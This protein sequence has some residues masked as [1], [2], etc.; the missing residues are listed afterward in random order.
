[1]HQ[2]IN[3]RASLRIAALILLITAPMLIGEILA[4]KL[5]VVYWTGG[6]L[7]SLIYQPIRS[8]GIDAH[9]CINGWPD[10]G[11]LCDTFNYAFSPLL[12][13]KE[14]W[15]WTRR[16]FIRFNTIVTTYDSIHTC[17]LWLY[18]TGTATHSNWVQAYLVTSPWEETTVTWATAPSVNLTVASDR[19]TPPFPNWEGWLSLNIAP[20]Y[21]NWVAGPNYGLQLRQQDLDSDDGQKFFSSDYLFCSLSIDS[22]WVSEETDCD[23]QNLVEICYEATDYIID[24]IFASLKIFHDGALVGAHTISETVPGFPPPNLGWVSSG[25]KC[26]YW[27]MSADYPGNEGCDFEIA[28]DVMNETTEILT[29]TDS[30]AIPDAE[31]VAWDGE[32]LWVTRSWYNSPL[33]TQR[34]FRVDP[35]THEVFDDSCITDH[36][37][38]GYTADCVWHDGY[39]WILGGGLSGQRAKLFKFDV[40]TCTVVDSSAALW[41]GARWGQGICYHDGWFYAC[42]SNGK[43]YRVETTPP[44]TSTLWLDLETIHP[45]LMSGAI[46]ADALVF[47]LGFIWIL[48]NPGPAGHVL[49]QFD[50]TGN[51]IDSFALASLTGFGPEGITFDGECF[52]YTDHAKDFVY[53]VC[54]WGCEDS[55]VVAVCLDSKAPEVAALCP[56]SPVYVGDS[57]SFN[58]LV[59]EYF[60]TSEPGSLIMDDGVSRIAVPLPPG[61]HT[62]AIPELC[63][64]TSFVMMIRDSFCNW[65]EDTCF[66]EVCRRLD[67]VLD[68]APCG[69]VSSCSSQTAN[70]MVI[71]PLCSSD[72]SSA[73]FTIRL[74]HDSGDST[75][76]YRAGPSAS[77]IFIPE[78]DST[79]ISL[80]DIPFADGDS[81]R[82]T[83]D[84]L[85]TPAGC[86]T[87]P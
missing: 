67:A 17:E 73:F 79:R 86:R 55:A 68:C 29:V 54:L 51:V 34:V 13:L 65:G 58:A 76:L 47:A 38:D 7:D 4:P 18:K 12:Q 71:D 83:L 1:M 2:G 20:I 85:F 10:D 74:Y 72:I 87:V 26:F 62:I 63:G 49:L 42:D 39:L 48:R 69:G 28:L 78:A 36:L 40:S 19:W 41:G 57:V 21:Q 33:V 31:G 52:W 23:G 75:V 16:S 56:P 11:I 64:L 82:I 14:D 35:I 9:I 3:S 77:V 46:S 22:L 61:G 59:A 32:F 8:E 6:A 60:G 37:F 81:V 84:S 30:F 24:S 53:R 15:H 70:F 25:T 66:L 45:G 44:Y 50:Y 5:R 80:R 27:N 43:I